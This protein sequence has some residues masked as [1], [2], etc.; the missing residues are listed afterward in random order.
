LT[1][2]AAFLKGKRID[3]IRSKKM[4]SLLQSEVAPI[5]D[6]RGSKAYKRLLLRQLV[7]AHMLKIEPELEVF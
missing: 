7:M 2:T 4:D 3:E 5:S 1:K 6:V